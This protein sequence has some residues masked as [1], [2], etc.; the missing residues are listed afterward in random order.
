MSP[1]ALKAEEEAEGEG[2]DRAEEPSK[3]T[4]LSFLEEG[5]VW[6]PL[7]DPCSALSLCCRAV[8]LLAAV[9]T[10]REEEEF[11]LPLLLTADMLLIP[12]PSRPLVRLTGMLCLSCLS[13]SL[14]ASVLRG[15]SSSELWMR[16]MPLT[17]SSSSSS[18]SVYFDCGKALFFS[19]CREG[20]EWSD[21]R[22]TCIGWKRKMCVCVCVLSEATLFC[23]VLHLWVRGMMSP[24][25][26][27]RDQCLPCLAVVANVRVN[28]E[29]R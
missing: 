27:K 5:E 15:S 12:M 6:S 14:S 16:T 9:S 24:L 19:I 26:A 10:V 23:T 29:V 3:L 8:G 1:E 22:H 13:L 28:V 18:S 4:F 17:S 2:E 20:Q 25:R 21:Y 11:L 7:F